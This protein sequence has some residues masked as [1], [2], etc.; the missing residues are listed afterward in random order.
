MNRV[1]RPALITAL[2]ALATG[3]GALEGQGA[4]APTKSAWTA[5]ILE[6]VIPTAGYAYAD[7]W[8]DGLLPGAVRV[9]GTVALLWAMTD[10]LTGEPGDGEPPYEC[11]TGCVYGIVATAV[12]CVWGVTGAVRAAKAWTPERAGLTLGWSPETSSLRVGVRVGF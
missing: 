12:G 4:D 2:L 6:Y 11:R 7:A 5:G 9:S 1:W 3:A 10:A 8:T